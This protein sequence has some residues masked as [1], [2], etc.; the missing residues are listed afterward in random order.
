M[1]LQEF[2]PFTLEH[3]EVPILFPVGG[4]PTPKQ[5]LGREFRMRLKEAHAPK[6]LTSIFESQVQ[7]CTLTLSDEDL[8]R[9]VTRITKADK[10][11]KL[12][13]TMIDDD[14]PGLPEQ[15][16]PP[17]QFF[18]CAVGFLGIHGQTDKP[19][20]QELYDL[21]CWIRHGIHLGAAISARIPKIDKN[22]LSRLPSLGGCLQPIRLPA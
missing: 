2:G 3:R 22:Q 12:S 18:V 7:V 9:Q 17:N 19:V 21:R 1:S 15:A 5:C 8:G 16:I 14:K 13:L 11:P 4:D 6:L 10:T 20:A